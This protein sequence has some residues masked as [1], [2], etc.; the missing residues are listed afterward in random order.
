MR[1]RD[2]EYGQMIY[3]RMSYCWARGMNFFEKSGN[4]TIG[5]R[6]SLWNCFPDMIENTRKIRGSLWTVIFFGI[7]PESPKQLTYKIRYRLT[8]CICVNSNR[9]D[10]YVKRSG[11]ISQVQYKA[12]N[13]SGRDDRQESFARRGRDRQNCF[14][15]RQWREYR[16]GETGGH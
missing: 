5:C 3:D 16:G 14:F 12:R 8:G 6:R 4:A 7:G 11:N 9:W 13:R 2:A 15:S 1:G 10:Q